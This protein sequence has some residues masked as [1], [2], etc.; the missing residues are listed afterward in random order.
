MTWAEVAG[1]T[2]QAGERADREARGI[3][4]EKERAGVLK[5]TDPRAAVQRP[6]AESKSATIG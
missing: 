2:G 4:P 3:V 5:G 6:G 1:T